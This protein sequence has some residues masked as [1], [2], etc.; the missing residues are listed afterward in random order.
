MTKFIQFASWASQNYHIL[1][2]QKF[3]FNFIGIA[4]TLILRDC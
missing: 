1:E 4:M 2:A 3:I